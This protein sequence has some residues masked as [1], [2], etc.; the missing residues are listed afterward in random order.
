MALAQQALELAQELG[1][2][3]RQAE[4]LWQLGYADQGNNKFKYWKSAIEL[5]RSSGNVGWLASNL[6][7][8]AL[9]LASNGDLETAQEYLNESDQLTRQFNLN[10]LP[11]DFHPAYGQI[12]LMCG[13]FKKA[14]ASFEES[15]KT[16]LK[17]GNRHEYLWARAHLG[18]VA[19]RQGNLEEANQ[20]FSET[21]RDFQK[22]KHTSGVVFAL[23]GKAG[24]YVA[25]DKT[26]YAACLVGWTDATREKFGDS[27]LLKEQ[28]YINQV[29]ATCIATMGEVAFSNAYRKGKTISLD[30]AVAY[31]LEG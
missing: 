11:R 23:E 24:S 7:T 1:D 31:A 3:H 15:A 10:P 30:E 29:L 4:A 12:A 21:A 17:F 16:H 22:D 19:L 14:R 20:I 27:R 2:V 26:D 8:L 13:D 5:A 28:E 18:F 6:S 9:Y 25:M